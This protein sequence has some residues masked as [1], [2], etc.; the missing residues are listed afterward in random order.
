MTTFHMHGRPVQFPATGGGFGWPL[1]LAV[2]GAAFAAIAL[3]ASWH[4]VSARLARP[5]L[6]RELPG[7]WTFRPIEALRGD[8]KDCL[9]EWEHAALDGL[10]AAVRMPSARPE[11]ERTWWWS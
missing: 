11:P 2:L 5:R 7:G 4:R 10:E 8:G 6:R 9:Y 1:L 3:A